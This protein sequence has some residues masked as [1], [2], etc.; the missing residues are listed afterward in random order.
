MDGAEEEEWNAIDSGDDGEEDTA[1]RYND[2]SEDPSSHDE[3]DDL[4]K[5]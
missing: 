5:F 2:T 3:D 4:N 1:I